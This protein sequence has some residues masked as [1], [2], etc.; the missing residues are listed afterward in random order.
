M[1]HECVILQRCFT[2]E[3]IRA[4]LPGLKSGPVGEWQQ[5]IDVMN[6]EARYAEMTA[7]ERLYEAGI[8]EAWDA[9]RISR[10]R[11][12]M[13]ELLSLVDLGSHAEKIVDT[14]FADPKRY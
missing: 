4:W 1:F 2:W 6:G 13:I 8:M 3:S 10:N 7:N 5:K 11:D 9:A 14:I 12:R